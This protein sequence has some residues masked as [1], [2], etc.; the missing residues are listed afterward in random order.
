MLLQK[1]CG[2]APILEWC[3]QNADKISTEI[4]R[5]TFKISN[6]MW[7]SHFLFF[8][9]HKQ[10]I[11]GVPFLWWLATLFFP[12][13]SYFNC[14][15]QEQNF[16]CTQYR[17]KIIYEY[18]FLNSKIENFCS[19]WPHHSSSLFP[20]FLEMATSDCSE[21]QNRPFPF[22]FL[23]HLTPQ[24]LLSFFFS[25]KCDWLD[26]EG[27]GELFILFL[28]EY[29]LGPGKLTEWLRWLRWRKDV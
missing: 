20:I 18:L 24:L 23:S 7:K 19:G 4:K 14:I 10:N 13:L 17:W 25:C 22:S 6:S 8:E 29:P 9:F 12:L 21:T 2:P 3:V 26:S 15:L 28:S 5:K 11:L 1:F 16:I 27:D